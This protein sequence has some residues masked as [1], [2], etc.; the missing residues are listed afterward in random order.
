MGRLRQIILNLL[1]NAIEFTES[2]TVALD[3]DVQSH[4]QELI[5]LHFCISDTGIGVPRD[6]QKEIFR[7]FEQADRSTTRRF[8]G[9]GLGL[10]ICSSLVKLM[11]G[12]IWVES[13]SGHGSQVHFTA[14][15]SEVEKDE[16]K[17]TQADSTLEHSAA[18]DVAND[19]VGAVSA[20]AEGF[21]PSGVRGTKPANTRQTTRTSLFG[22]V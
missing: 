8:G 5:K 21:L 6:K 7:A 17:T 18:S 16:P 22:R 13:E 20:W 9:T 12:D 14:Q 1:G 19:G 4:D 15:F 10:A 3:V 11:G 2:G